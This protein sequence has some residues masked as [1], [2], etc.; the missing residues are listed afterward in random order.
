MDLDG[1]AT[2]IGDKQQNYS[3]A[4]ETEISKTAGECRVLNIMAG[5]IR[6]SSVAGYSGCYSGYSAGCYT[7]APP[8]PV[9]DMSSNESSWYSRCSGYGR[10]GRPPSPKKSPPSPPLPSSLALAKR[11][12]RAPPP[13]PLLLL[14]L[15]LL[16]IGIGIGIGAGLPDGLARI[17]ASVRRC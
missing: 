16:G 12:R 5:A 17:S 13:L 4:V 1:L 3:L 8:S 9:T 7:L 14:L 11:R 2:T 6:P 15:L 10:S